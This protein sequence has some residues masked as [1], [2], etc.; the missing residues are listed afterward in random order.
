VNRT[1]ALL[2]GAAVLSTSAGACGFIPGHLLTTTHQA[3]V[4][5]G[6]P[7]DLLV[8]LVWAE[9]RYCPVATSEAGA[10]GLGQLLPGTAADMNV[11]DRRDPVQNLYGSARYLRL[12]WDMFRNWDLAF[13]A[14]HDGPGNVRAGRA[15]TRGR[16]HV[17]FILGTY[18]AIRKQGGLS[19]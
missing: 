5:Y 15:S 9:S 18:D 4:A 10:V 1:A 6:L 8:S 16:N 19:K 13:L 17:A 11:A 7:K 12:M 2:L 14:Y 3:E